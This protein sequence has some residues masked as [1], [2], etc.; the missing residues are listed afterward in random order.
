VRARPDA[1]SRWLWLI[2]WLLL[3]PH[4]VVLAVLWVAFVAMTVVG[5]VAVLFTGRYPRGIFDFNVGVLRWS[6]RVGYYG[7][8]VLGTD[9]YPPFTLAQDPD[10]PADLYIDYPDRIPRHQPLVAWLLALPHAVLLGAI[11][12][13]TW[14]VYDNG[15]WVAQARVSLVGAAV[16]IAGVSLAVTGEHPRGL[17][18]LLTGVARW[19]L[20][21]AAYVALLTGRYPPFRLDQGGDEP[22]DPDA[23]PPAGTGTVAPWIS[24]TAPQ[25]PP[26]PSP[27][28]PAATVTRV[29]ALC[30]GVVLMLTGLLVG[31]GSG[32][33]LAVDAARNADG[34][35]TTS[36]LTLTTP[37]AAVTSSDVTIEG[38]DTW[39]LRWGDFGKVRV[40]AT[41]QGE[42]PLFLGVGRVSDVD[43]WL[44]GTGRDELTQ[45]WGQGDTAAYRRVGGDVRP[46]S[47][48][49][50]Q[51]F[52]V[53]QTSGTGTI[54]LEWDALAST[55]SYVFVLANADGSLSVAAGTRLGVNV[56]ALVPLGSGL[57]VTA[58]LF[59]L[60]GVALIYGGASGLGRHHSGSP[61]PV[62]P[63][64][65][66][67]PT[68]T[69]TADP[70][71]GA[72][73]ATAP[74]AVP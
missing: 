61:A 65:P 59:I 3:I 17:Y 28:G 19:S 40:T 72:S 12:G 35:A 20:R 62:V 10:Y 44:S 24:P 41:G 51:T 57:L 64:P 9:R 18:N 37:T 67:E 25:P 48:P 5:Y 16:L 34:Y 23:P 29:V 71:V 73:A 46:L 45:A 32:V 70:P 43:R 74:K 22:V 38:T 4:Y 14:Q 42:T 8:Q 68:G 50:D 2:K 56:P 15:S 1:P 30:A 53:S 21:V 26:P 11:A 54:Q 60:I 39:R 6:W 66:A 52:W 13:S 49:G 63:T 36:N 55:G 31:I 27:P 58:G 47:R 7:Y 69:T 33:L